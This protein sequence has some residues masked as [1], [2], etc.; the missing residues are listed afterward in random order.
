MRQLLVYLVIAILAFTSCKKEIEPKSEKE[1]DLEA[2]DV[3]YDLMY[4]WYLWYDNIPEVNKNNYESPYD[5]MPAMLYKPIDRWSY[6]VP[7]SVFESYYA[8]SFAGHGYSVGIDAEN[9][10]RI[11]M[12]YQKSNLYISGVRRGWE[13]KEVNNVD[14][15]P[16]II[17]GDGT[18]YNTVMGPKTVGI[19]NTFLFGRPGKPDTTI[20]SAKSSFTVNSVLHFDTLHLSTGVTGHLVFESFIE[21]SFN[22]LSEAFTFFKNNN[23]TDLIIDL[24]YNGGGML[25]VAHEL[26]SYIIGNGSAD[27]VFVKYQHNIKRAGENDE[28]AFFKDTNLP[29]NLPRLVV[30]TS[31][32]SASASEV[33]INSL[34]PHITVTTVGD[35]TYGKPSGMYLFE[36]PQVNPIYAFV[37]VTFKLVNADNEGDYFNG[38]PVDEYAPDDITRDF[39]DRNEASLAEA[40]SVLTGST[41]KSG[42]IYKTSFH[43][44]ERP[45]WQS[46]TFVRKEINP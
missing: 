7:L 11:A 26:A 5:L 45:D 15:A 9:K 37:P 14:I 36:Y 41:T 20:V 46:N 42:Y 33:I 34:K 21:P 13:I 1:M 35:T 43:V 22:E 8:G 31:R 30:I 25:S 4:D 12:I 39:S 44:S 6:S 32:E 17:S 16:L 29:M 24:R 18:T 40:I 2:R 3:L 38:I 23:I 27:K 19:T 28:T 10:A